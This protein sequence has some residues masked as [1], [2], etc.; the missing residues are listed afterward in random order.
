M[1]RTLLSV[2]ACTSS[3][4]VLSDKG[5]SSQEPSVGNSSRGDH[6][7]VARNPVEDVIVLG[8]FV[9]GGT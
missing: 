3:T 1:S 2:T 8:Q 7:L 6:G 5:R 4:K 9:A